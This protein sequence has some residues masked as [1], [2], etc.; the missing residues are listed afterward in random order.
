MAVIKRTLG[1][2]SVVG[3]MAFGQGPETQP[4]QQVAQDKTET[5]LTPEVQRIDWR[6]IFQRAGELYKDLLLKGP[7]GKTYV[8]LADLYF[9]GEKPVQA[10]FYIELAFALDPDNETLRMKVEE[11]Q[12][13]IDYLAERFATYTKKANTENDSHSFG[14]MAAI[15]FHQGFFVEAFN[16]LR[17]GMT[18]YGEDAPFAH[19][20]RTFQQDIKAQIKVLSE[21]KQTFIQAQEAGDLEKSIEMVG[22][23]TFL[24]LGNPDILTLLKSVMSANPEAVNEESYWLLDE[25][26]KFYPNEQ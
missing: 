5:V 9:Q 12:G 26:T 4:Q 24:S 25:F 8:E 21:L 19:L 11:I 18:K 16:I 7:S 13:R 1:I 3:L 6:V 22:Q 17:A 2:F 14:S 15:K 20:G 23:M 10:K